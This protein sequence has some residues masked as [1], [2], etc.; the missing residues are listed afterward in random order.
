VEVEITEI[1]TL[2]DGSNVHRIAFHVQVLIAAHRC[3]ADTT[4]DPKSRRCY[5]VPKYSAQFWYNSSNV[6]LKFNNA[7]WK[8]TIRFSLV[9]ERSNAKSINFDKVSNSTTSVNALN[10]SG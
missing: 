7:D 9:E 5:C 6:V 8:I 4:L 10:C 3:D 2:E 1:L